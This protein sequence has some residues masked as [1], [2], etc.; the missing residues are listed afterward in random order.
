MRG[1]QTAQMTVAGHSMSPLLNI[2]DV[3]GLQMID[4]A[5][6][7][8]GQVITFRDPN[9]PAG[10][11]THRVAAINGDGQTGLFLLTRGDRIMMFDKPLKE[12]DLVG[13]VVWRERNGRRLQLEQGSGARLSNILGKISEIQRR[14]ISGLSFE[15]MA[16]TPDGVAA[17]NDRVLNRRDSTYARAVR[18]SGTTCSRILAA[19]VE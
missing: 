16:L 17:V 13:R 18:K 12:D 1:E 5:E 2:G 14:L 4:L 10:L 9:D 7:K 6:I 15:S 3:V 19:F 8:T 11:L